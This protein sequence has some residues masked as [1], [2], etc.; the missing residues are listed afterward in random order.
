MQCKALCG[1]RDNYILPLETRLVAHTTGAGLRLAG[2]EMSDPPDG[3][4]V[5][6]QEL[7]KLLEAR[8]QVGMQRQS[9]SIQNT[10][11]FS[12]QTTPWMFAQWMMS[13]TGSRRVATETGFYSISTAYARPYPWPDHV[14]PITVEIDG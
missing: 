13:N 12:V 2:D 3:S 1:R 10:V 4:E 7:A 9:W 11:R 14:G 6:R 8:L 5:N